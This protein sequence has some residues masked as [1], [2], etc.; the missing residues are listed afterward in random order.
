M[1]LWSLDAIDRCVGQSTTGMIIVYL[2]AV[3]S[4]M[5]IPVI[6]ISEIKQ[7]VSQT[8]I[9]DCCFEGI[10]AFAAVG[11]LFMMQKSSRSLTICEYGYRFQGVISLTAMG[12]G[13]GLAIMTTLINVMTVD[14]VYTVNRGKSPLSSWFAGADVPLRCGRGG[15]RFFA[16]SCSTRLNAKV[17][18]LSR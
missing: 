11:G 9:Y 15:N 8:Y 6:V 5:A 13:I 2:A 7:I 16:G 17:G 1:R 10:F 12:T 14:H 3:L 18:H 4:L